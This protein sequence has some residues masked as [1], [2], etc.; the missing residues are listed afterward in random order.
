MPEANIIYEIVLLLLALPF[1]HETIW[2]E[3]M[4]FQQNSYKAKRYLRS[5]KGANIARYALHAGLLLSFFLLK[6]L[7]WALVV[8]GIGVFLLGIVRLRKKYK[9]PL[10]LTARVYRLWTAEVVIVGLLAVFLWQFCESSPF[11]ALLLYV[12]F[13]PLMVLFANALLVPLEASISRYYYNDAKRILQNHKGLTI[14]GITGSYGKTSTKHFLERMLS[15]KYNV[16]MTPGNFNTTLGV[17]ITIRQHL[18]PYHDIFIVEMGAKQMGDIKEIC[19]LVNPSIGILTS[20]GEQHLETFKSIE[21]IQQTKF[22]LIESL[23]TDGLAVLN[24][25]YEYVRNKDLSSIRVKN[26][27]PYAM[28]ERALSYKHPLLL[29]DNIRFDANAKAQF[30][31]RC[32][33]G[34]V[35]D[36]FTTSLLGSYNLSNLLACYIVAKHLKC[37]SKELSKAI[38]DIHPVTHRLSV[39]HMQN[40]TT[41]LDDAYN[42]NPQGA[43][44]ALKVLAQYPGKK[45]MVITPGMVE[46]GEK[47]EEY[48]ERLGKQIAEHTDY[49]FIVGQYNRESLLKGIEKQ[50]YNKENIFAC[51]NLNEAVLRMNQIAKAGD[52][53]LYE[54]DLPDTFK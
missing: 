35:A 5:I 39:M 31:I 2:F 47:Q 53:V 13:A 46:L 38:K 42:S 44:M 7:P 29:I 3:N 14:I 32:K 52:V 19:A 21:N 8:L 33:Q 50:G 1:L 37:S 12:C 43:E 45:K 30:D 6:M 26:I 10:A 27:L 40:G 34:E 24:T 15:E 16:L 51:A 36:T 49:A 22:E 25:D 48:N 18:K 20:V 17:V 28:Q 54:N 23:P 41:V 11:F 9:K 4:F